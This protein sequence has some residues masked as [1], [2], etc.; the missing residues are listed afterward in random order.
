MNIL[1]QIENFRSFILHVELLLDLDI[2][3]S[4]RSSLDRI[5]DHCNE[6]RDHKIE[7]DCKVD[8][9]NEISSAIQADLNKFMKD[10]QCDGNL[11]DLEVD[12]TLERVI[13]SMQTCLNLLDSSNMTEIKLEV[14]NVLDKIEN[15]AYVYDLKKCYRFKELHY[16]FVYFRHDQPEIVASYADANDQVYLIRFNKNGDVLKEK[17][18]IKPTNCTCLTKFS[19][20]S[21]GFAAYVLVINSDMDSSINITC[22]TG[23]VALPANRDLIINL[24]NNFNYTSHYSKNLTTVSAHNLNHHFFLEEGQSSVDSPFSVGINIYSL[25]PRYSEDSDVSVPF[26]CIPMGHEILKLVADDL[27]HLYIFYKHSRR[28]IVQRRVNTSTWLVEQEI[29]FDQYNWNYNTDDLQFKLIGDS[30]WSIYDDLTGQ[31]DFYNI[32]GEYV[33]TEEEYLRPRLRMTNDSSYSNCLYDKSGNIYIF[34]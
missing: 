11:V 19:L 22:S 33:S 14:V 18:F 15:D 8:K 32:R 24:D 20:T 17:L 30:L 16:S 31:L 23:F 2:K 7:S 9:L 3:T 4:I 12:R 5:R 29:L 10:M 1:S 28:G 21:K 27:C 13:E 26:S 6:L 25:V 34:F